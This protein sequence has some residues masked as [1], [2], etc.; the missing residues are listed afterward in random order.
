MN[1]MCNPVNVN[2]RYQFCVNPMNQET[3]IAREAADPSMIFF[4]GKYYVF[5]S[6]TLGVWV[7]DD[8][9]H[10]DNHRLPDTLPLYDYAPDVRV[11]GDYVYFSASKRGEI[12][13]FY[14]T[15]DIL[16]GPYE[17]I[18]GSFDFWDPNLFIDTDG[19][20][21]FYWG[22][23]DKTPVWGVE[24]DA[25]T[26]RPMGEKKALIY[27]DAF[28]KGFERIGDDHCKIPRLEKDAEEL[29]RKHLKD[30]NLCEEQM[31]SNAVEMLKDSFRNWP[32]IEGA[33]MDKF[34]GKYYLQ[35]ACPGT[36]YNIYADAVYVGDTP[37]G[38]FKLAKN[39]PFSYKPGGFING[40]GHG[41]T[42]Y[43]RY[44]NLWHISTMSISMNFIFERR[45]GLWP[46]GIDE[47]GELFCNQRYGDWP[48]A[49]P[50]GRFAPWKEPEWYLLSYGKKACASSFMEGH[51]PE[52]A[53][54]ENIKTWW[55]ASAEDEKRQ[56]IVDLEKSFDVYA[57]QINFADDK[58][59]V[60]TSVNW[61]GDAIKRYI[62]EREVFTRWILE[63]SADGDSYEVLEDK[64]LA[65]TDFS[66]DLVVKTNGVQ[67][68]FVRLTV[69]EVPYGQTPC[70][71][72][73][74]I[75]G[76]GKGEKA[77][78]PEFAV[79]RT[80]NLDMEIEIQKSN[81]IGY[82][83]LWGHK[84]DKLYHSFLTYENSVRIG[85]LVKDQKY[86]VRVDAFNENGITEGTLYPDAI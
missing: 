43:D 39:N 19:R 44:G 63:G 77:C 51:G 72:G 76:K 38:P 46:A 31:D 56:L 13:S 47:D 9:V 45:V 7:S 74:R 28:Q 52:N 50:E 78:A 4:H 12:C 5:A 73:L 11:V 26:M 71:S 40:A 54:D 83:V 17:E 34:D 64:S 33:W 75:F 41:S 82:N 58:I 49:V 21:Y 67:I 42:M 53:V 25:K 37:L 69:L 23:S 1:Y 24:L 15:Q 62:E 60:D 61:H 48:V 70:I 8:M 27:S 81:A 68:R 65:K 79:R 10:W 16:N 36:Q 86:Y 84:P 20:F 66:H 80:G 59:M 3:E 57:I 55:R 2:Y 30:N 22:C 6:M 32:Y 85:A 29:Y 35:Y 14:R 18:P